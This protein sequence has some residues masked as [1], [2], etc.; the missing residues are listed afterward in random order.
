ML[1]NVVFFILEDG[2]SI[3]ARNIGNNLNTFYHI[4]LDHGDTILLLKA[5]NDLPDYMSQTS[6]LNIEAEI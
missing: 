2:D 4:N 5:D 6:T 1:H 3:F